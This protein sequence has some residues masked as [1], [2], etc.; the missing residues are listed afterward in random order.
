MNKAIFALEDGTVFEGVAFGACGTVVGETCI[1]TSMSGYQEAITDPTNRGQI[2]AMTYPLIGNYGINNEDNESGSPQISGLVIEELP[3]HHSNWR[4]TGAMEPW[5]SQNKVVGIQGVDTRKLIALLREKGALKA[6]LTTDLSK[7]EAIQK[8]REATDL[9]EL[10]PVREASTPKI[11]QWSEEPASNANRPIVKYKIAAY[12]FGIRRSV[13]RALGN[14][15][16]DITVI[17]AD[18]SAND[19]L[20]M[21]LDG[22]FLSNGPGDPSVL[23]Q[24]HSEIRTLLGK[25]PIFAINLGVLVLAHALGASTKRLKFDHCGNNQPV[26]N[27]RHGSVQIT[28]QN[29]KFA[30]DCDSVPEDVEITHINLNDDTIEGFSSKKYPAAGVQ[31]FPPAYANMEDAA[32]FF[33]DFIQL[34]EKNKA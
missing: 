25:L 14:A 7:N 11:Y 19:V 13:L 23:C 21:G 31:F 28:G 27:L 12:D 26:K 30:I 34:I 24:I 3:K 32:C 29:H 1:N 2:L 33:D 8:A 9:K 6:C 17:N 18:T 10:D 16:F 5:L 4:S 22:V 20:S 15:G